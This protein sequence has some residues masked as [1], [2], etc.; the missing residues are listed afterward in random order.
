M[1][2]WREDVELD[3][4]V[5]RGWSIAA[6]ARHLGRDRKTVRAY[7]RGERTPGKRRRAVPDGFERFEAYVRARL[8]EDPHVWATVL[9]DEVRA[10]GYGQSYPSFTRQL[11]ARDLRPHCEACRGVKGRPTIEIAHPPGE[12]IQWDWLELP[13]APW[14][15]RAYVLLGTLSFSGKF[16]AVFAESMDQAHLVEALD[17]VLRRL[18]GT[19]RRWR[20]DRMA[21]VVDPRTGDVQ[22]SF[23][24]VAKHYGVAVDPCPR[25]RANR[26]GA[27]EKSVHYTTQRWW[28][29]AEVAELVDAQASLDRFC[30]RV[31]DARTRPSAL[32]G[33]MSED[34][35]RWVAP[36]AAFDTGPAPETGRSRRRVSVAELAE[37]EALRGL[38]ALPF[39][40][41]VEV[42]RQVSASALVGFRGNRYSVPPGLLGHQVMV[43]HRLGTS[44]IEI[45]SEAGALV[46]SHR[47]VLAG[48]GQIVRDPEHHAALEAVVLDAFTTA[49][50]C[51]RKANRP[52][53]ENAK[54]EAAKLLATLGSE[55][56]VD[57][58]RYAQLAEVTR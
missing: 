57:L 15:G 22:A 50:P 44:S 3:A 1:L 54:A 43:R 19:T 13:N 17:G 32:M 29:T 53:G 49:R 52:P 41:T 38:P 27:V 2:T 4:L 12:E 21:T 14:G 9:F 33:G 20:V 55:V 48:A 10:L 7:V 5:E 11:R 51:D 30:E 25:R 35:S 39:P 34:P 6:I 26:K 31:A 24:P 37:R 18:G 40:A 16:R 36:G 8:V 58:E 56:R 46:A 45:H 47:L 28:R 23:A 42:A